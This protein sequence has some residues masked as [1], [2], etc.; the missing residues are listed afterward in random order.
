[1]NLPAQN[2]DDGLFIQ[3]TQYI[4]HVSKGKSSIFR[5]SASF[6]AEYRMQLAKWAWITM[7]VRSSTTD[8]K[9]NSDCPLG[10]GSLS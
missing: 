4:M 7:Y 9:L 8:T 5:T 6:A 3:P 1:M 10:R 2:P